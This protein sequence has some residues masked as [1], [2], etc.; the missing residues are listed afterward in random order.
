MAKFQL[1]GHEVKMGT[2]GES[3]NALDQNKTMVI[4]QL[5]GDEPIKPEFK[6]DLKTINDVFSNYKPTLDVSFEDKE[7]NPVE[8]NLQ[9]NSIADFGKKALIKNSPF[10]QD[11]NANQIEFQKFIKMLKIKQMGNIVKD[12]DAKQS[13]I[14]ALQSMISELEGTGA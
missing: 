3:V 11:V 6:T 12:P 5:T 14:N 4:T 8:N 2:G 10:L 1:G 7:G 13:Y 9:F